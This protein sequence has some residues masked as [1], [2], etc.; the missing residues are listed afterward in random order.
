MNTNNP[1]DPA[2]DETPSAADD[3]NA[4]SSATAA[5]GKRSWTIPLVILATLMLMCSGV[6]IWLL[7][8]DLP[9]VTQQDLDAAMER[10]EQQGPE[11]Y[12]ITVELGGDSPGIFE[13]QVRDGKVQSP[14]SRNGTPV[15][16]RSAR[17]TWS[18]QGQFETI[19]RELELA[20]DPE[21]EMKSATANRLVLRGKFDPKFGYPARFH[22]FV[23]GHGPE[24][25]WEVKKFRPIP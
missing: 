18:V 17:E 22:R 25:Y 20:A 12:D 13:V 5:S 19:S 14:P 15:E 10:W 7:R 23:V 2:S 24:V 16:S 11:N 6:G 21:Q 3:T 4:A 1:T 8:G 9:E